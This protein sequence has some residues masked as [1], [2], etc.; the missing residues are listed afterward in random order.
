METKN[1]WL[2]SGERGP[3]LH[4]ALIA[5]EENVGGIHSP[6]VNASIVAISQVFFNL[7]P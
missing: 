3:I 2:L 4:W 1:S 7:F 6:Y 5:T